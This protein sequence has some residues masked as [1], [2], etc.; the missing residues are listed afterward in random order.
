M[1]NLNVR[2]RLGGPTGNERLTAMTGVV[3]I[4]L[5]AV[6]GV[7][8]LFLQPLLSTHI[9]V[10]VLLVPPV[11]LKLASTGYRLARY[12]AGSRA[13]REKGAPAPLLR[14]LAPLVV[15]STLA[16]FASGILLIA[17][18]PGTRFVLPL[19]QASFITW[20]AATGAHVL[21]HLLRVS[22]L[23]TA[24]LRK[25]ERVPGSALRASLLAGSLVA[26]TIL[27]IAT[28]PLASVWLHWRMEG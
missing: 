23:A 24:D 22:R 20:L 7:T 25:H 8:V 3:L 17:L 1:S 6:E 10:G 28:L 5:L 11:A 27:A 26:G 15:V 18:G 21:G 16:L 9:F 4:V 14:L 2:R 12:Y 19:H 13:F